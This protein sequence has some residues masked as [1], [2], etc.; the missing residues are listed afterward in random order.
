MLLIYR[1]LYFSL[2]YL[3]ISLSFPRPYSVF[4]LRIFSTLQLLPQSQ[5]YRTLSDRLVTVGSLQ[6]H[7]GFAENRNR[8]NNNNFNNNNLNNNSN[9]NTDDNNSNNN[10]FVNPKILNSKKNNGDSNHDGIHD[11]NAADSPN[12]ENATGILQQNSSYELSNYYEELL[13]RFESVQEKHVKLRLSTIQQVKLRTSPGDGTSKA[14]SG[15]GP[16]SGLSGDVGGEQGP[17]GSGTS[18]SVLFTED[19]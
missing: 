17:T 18:S 15:S 14:G 5:A 9:S 2:Y 10:S 12:D 1:V 6:M 7:I 3:R 13:C 16:G 11:G 4:H 8:N 19:F